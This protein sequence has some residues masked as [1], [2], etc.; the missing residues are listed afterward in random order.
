MFWTIVDSRIKVT[1]SDKYNTSIRQFIVITNCKFIIEYT[2]IAKPL[3]EKQKES[4]Q[5][6]A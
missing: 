1:D 2:Y 5:I 4:Y 6:Q 3:T